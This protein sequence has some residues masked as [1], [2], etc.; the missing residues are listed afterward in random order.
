MTFLEAVVLARHV[1]RDLARL[2]AAGAAHGAV[3]PGAIRVRRGRAVLLPPAG[4][5]AREYRDP[6]RERALLRDPGASARGDARADVYA[7]G[8]WLYALLEGGPPPCGPASP[9]ARP[10]PAAVATIAARAMAPGNARYPSARALRAD[11][12]AVLRLGG[13]GGIGAVRPEDL[14]SF[15]GAVAPV[16]PTVLRPFAVARARRRRWSRLAAA[17]LLIAAGLPVFL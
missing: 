17:A 1:A 6:D 9:F 15:A 3:G 5:V 10:A 2:H 12:D 14:P 11:L 8:A 13:R 7:V 4:T 16:R